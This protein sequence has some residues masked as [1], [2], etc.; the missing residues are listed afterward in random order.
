MISEKVSKTALLE[1]SKE[2]KELANKQMLKEVEEKGERKV[3]ELK[4]EIRKL[5]EL[6]VVVS[7]N[8]NKDIHS[9]VKKATTSLQ[10][11][12]QNKSHPG[13]QTTSSFESSEFL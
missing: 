11:Q 12:L 2:M 5:N 3:V 10:A 7:E 8:I 4:E 1:M 13:G 6:L 9:A